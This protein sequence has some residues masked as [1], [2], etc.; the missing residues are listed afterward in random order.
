MTDRNPPNVAYLR[1][2]DRADRLSVD[3]A[4]LP[5]TALLSQI[6]VPPQWLPTPEAI[7]EWMRLCSILIEMKLLTEAS[8]SPLAQLCALHG[9]IVKL[10]AAGMSP[11][12]S[13]LGALRNLQNDFGLSPLAQGKVKTDAPKEDP[14]PNGFSGRGRK[15]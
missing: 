15:P 8:L 12:A 13:L 10:Y 1:G 11:G 2:T 7:K 3:T 9:N 6:P 5:D 4:H 14:K